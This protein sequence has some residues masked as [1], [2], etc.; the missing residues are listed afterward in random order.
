MLVLL[1]CPS[2]SAHTHTHT[3]S[4][5]PSFTYSRSKYCVWNL[6]PTSTCKYTYVLVTEADMGP[7]A[8][9]L[10]CTHSYD[11]P[12]CQC[13]NHL[14]VSYS[15][16]NYCLVDEKECPF[17]T[18]GDQCVL[19]VHSGTGMSVQVHTV[20]H[21]LHTVSSYQFILAQETSLSATEQMLT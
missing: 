19:D 21:S 6:G 13:R 8:E 17:P 12:C 20:T 18:A 14:L 7:R 9:G 3:H 5:T 11:S 1:C 2:P 16:H 4:P 15:N 10:S